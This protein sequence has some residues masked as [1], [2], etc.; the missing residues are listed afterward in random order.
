M[1][2]FINDLNKLVNTID[3]VDRILT[4]K[5]RVKYI[6]KKFTEIEIETLL[7]ALECFDDNEAENG[8]E[9]G[10]RPI[11]KKLESKLRAV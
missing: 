1:T 9:F 4:Q 11:I 7:M 6:T 5:P 2:N 10:Y 8:D 3:K